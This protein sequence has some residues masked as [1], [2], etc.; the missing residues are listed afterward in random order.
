MARLIKVRD[1]RLRL[2][3]ETINTGEPI[4]IH[5]RKPI[6]TRN[7]V[8]IRRSIFAFSQMSSQLILKIESFDGAVERGGAL[9]TVLKANK[10]MGDAQVGTPTYVKHK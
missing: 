1:G 5:Q 8:E 2:I 7:G 9:S 3:A 10:H 6:K 4:R